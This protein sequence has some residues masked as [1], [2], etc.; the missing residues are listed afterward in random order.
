[1]ETDVSEVTIAALG[2]DRFS[3]SQCAFL[4]APRS[5]LGVSVALTPPQATALLVCQEDGGAPEQSPYTTMASLLWENNLT[6]LR[7]LVSPVS[8]S[9]ELLYHD[10][11]EIRRLATS[12][13]EGT[14]LSAH[15]GLP[16]LVPANLLKDLDPTL[17][18]HSSR[19]DVLY[20]STV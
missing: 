1:M 4:T 5:R 18:S 3:G 15:F 13:G 9:S 14:V 19:M 12:D 20:F 17:A 10:G 7:V 8:A 16:L 2:V 11:A 6:P